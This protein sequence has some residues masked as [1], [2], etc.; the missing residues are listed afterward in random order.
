M[1]LSAARFLFYAAGPSSEF[2]LIT[3]FLQGMVNGILLTEY[4]KYLSEVVEPRLIGMGVAAFY[5]VS[6]NGGTILCNFFG[7]IAMDWLNSRGVYALFSALNAAG[8]LLYLY[9]G[10][11]K[12]TK[13]GIDRDC[14]G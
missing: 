3:F 10:L 2:L 4:V 7:G 5:A 9:F 13:K 11:H 12:T 1:A 14:W 6:S 8:T